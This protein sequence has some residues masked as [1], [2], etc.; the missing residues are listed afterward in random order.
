[1]RLQASRGSMSLGESQGG[2]PPDSVVDSED[3]IL[4]D[5]QRLIER[6]HDPKP[7]AMVQIVLAP[8]S[9]FSVTGELM[10]QSAIL[11]REHGVHLHTHLA[12]TQ[13][14]EAFCLQ[15]FGYR[16]VPI[17]KASIGL[18][19]MSG[20]PIR[21]MLTRRRSRS[22]RTPAAVWR[23]AH[24]PICAWLPGSPRY[25]NI[26][27]QALSWVWVWMARR[28]MM[29]RICWRKPARPCCWP[30]CG[31]GSKALHLAAMAHRPAHR[32]PGVGTGH[33]RRSSGFGPD[34][35][36]SLEAGKCADLIAINLNRLEYSGALH[37]P[38]AALLFCAPVN[39]DYNVIG[40]QVIV[41]EGRIDHPGSS[42][43]Y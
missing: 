1:M 43:P 7:G 32:P 2:L 35:I 23:T 4:K 41:R 26:C 33:P 30:G 39:V 20:L 14:E 40:G 10:R 11:A 6:Y 24:P 27:R 16:P 17:C 5:S 37:D 3:A 36:G 21:C 8:C 18:A 22:I 12:E 38:V 28:A 15:K 34:D 9:P 13:D 31:P 29:A 19:R 42:H 25:A